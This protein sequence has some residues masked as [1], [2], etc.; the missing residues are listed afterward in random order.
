MGKRQWVPDEWWQW[1]AWHAPQRFVAW[2]AFRVAVYATSGRYSSQI[3]PDLTALDAIT[4][5]IDGE[6]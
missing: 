2:C 5:W 1:L 6:V 3:V 4:R